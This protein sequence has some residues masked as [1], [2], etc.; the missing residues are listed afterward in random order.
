MIEEL[1]IWGIPVIFGVFGA[2]VGSFLNVVI[3]RVPLGI[4]V[5]DP[6]RSF[7]PTCEKA[8]PWYLNIPIFSWL[9]LRGRS[10]C[11]HTRISPRYCLVELLTAILFVWLGY[12]YADCSIGSAALLCVW[13]ALAV[14]IIF[15]DAERLIVFRS[16]TLI[17]AAAGLGACWLNPYLLIDNEVF[18]GPD[19]LKAGFIGA[20]AGYALIRL[21][22]EL[23]KLLFGS[24]H[25]SYEE[26][27]PWLLKEPESEEEELQLVIDGKPHDWSMLFHRESDKAVLTCTRLNIDRVHAYAD[28][29]VTLYADR[30][31]TADGRT[32]MLEDIKSA[33][34]ALT[35][36]R[37]KREAMGA[38]DAWIMMMIGC[39]GGWQA[40]V[41][42]IFAASLLGIAQAIASRLSFG[43]NMP[44]G[45]ALLV[46]GF[47]WLLG[48]RCLWVMYLDYIG[49]A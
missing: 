32:H 11:C 40:V 31:E 6:A 37:A 18:T 42:C 27:V 7:C 44:F 41:F 46:A 29:T 15:I 10:A 2:C 25:E 20:L 9:I 35:E 17:A 19:A 16:H 26:P 4:P 47:I 49:A 1:P 24:W 36:I 12:E 8:I 21:I 34:G 23:G 13:A 22:I 14:C 3:Y 5:N 48:G 45:P 30:I 38:G 39:I 28:C 43:R 33:E